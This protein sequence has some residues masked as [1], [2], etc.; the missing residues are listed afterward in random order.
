MQVVLHCASILWEHNCGPSKS[1]LHRITLTFKFS[2]TYVF[3]DLRKSSLHCIVFTMHDLMYDPMHDLRCMSLYR[4]PMY[5]FVM[6]LYM[7]DTTMDIN[8]YV[9]VF[10][11]YHTTSSTFY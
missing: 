7:I 5:D 1:S 4:L 9:N 3:R 10:L 11:S 2:V 6:T 8:E